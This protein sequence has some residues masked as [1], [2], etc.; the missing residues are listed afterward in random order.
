MWIQAWDS[1]DWYGYWCSQVVQGLC[2]GEANRLYRLLNDPVAWGR[3]ASGTPGQMKFLA[4]RN[5][6]LHFSAERDV[7]RLHQ[8]RVG[9]ERHELVGV[10]V[11]GEERD[12]RRR[13]RC[14][15]GFTITTR[16]CNFSS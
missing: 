12:P 9:V 13:E 5:E 8:A 15:L 3:D 1:N 10:A 7:A 16:N 6:Q 2:R 4:G 14:G 11:N